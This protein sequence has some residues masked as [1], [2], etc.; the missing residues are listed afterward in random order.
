MV[1]PAKR[2]ELLAQFLDRRRLHIASD[3]SKAATMTELS[4]A[5]DEFIRGLCEG[6]QGIAVI[7]IGGYGRRELGP[8]SDLD[9]LLLHK[10]RL[11]VE[12]FTESLWYTIWDSRVGLDYSVRTVAQAARVAEADPRALF[13]MLDAR[14]I[15]GD[16]F[17][18]AN[19]VS[20]MHDRFVSR[21]DRYR[22][23]MRQNSE[24]RKR[25]SGELAFL[26]EPDVKESHGGLRDVVLLRQLLLADP[27]GENSIARLNE[28]AQLLLK[29]RNLLQVRSDRASNRLNLQDQDGIAQSLGMVD[30][31][32][33]MKQVSEAGRFIS[34]SLEEK[35]R[36]T[37]SR[38]LSHKSIGDAWGAIPKGVFSHGSEICIDPAALGD[39]DAKVI[40]RIAATSLTLGLGICVDALEICSERLEAISDI[41]DQ[42]TLNSLIAILSAGAPG[43][44]VME[45]LDHYGLLDKI[46]PEWG[47][48]RYRPQRNAYHTYTVDRHL[49]E[50]AVGAGKLRRRVKRPDLLIVAALLHDIG[51]GIEGDHSLVGAK[52]ARSISERMGLAEGDVDI[53]ERL[54]VHHLLLADTATRRDISDPKTIEDVAS[55]VVDVTTLDLLEVLTE[56]DSRATGPAAWS[57]WKE[58][59]IAKLCQSTRSYLKDGSI[60]LP[61]SDIGAVESEL[62]SSFDDSLTV[63]HD[64]DYLYIA[65]RDHLGLFSKVAGTLALYN[66]NIVSAD[67]YSRGDVAVEKIK[68]V[69]PFNRDTNW[70]RFEVDLRKAIDDHSYLERRIAE[71]TTSNAR[72]RRSVAES[73]KIPP[74]VTIYDDASDR[75]TVV[76][77]CGPDEVGTLYRLTSAIASMD[78]DIAH[79]KALTIG[80]DVVDTFYIVNRDGST[81]EDSS[82][83]SLLRRSLLAVVTTELTP[84]TRSL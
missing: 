39:Y 60:Q 37:E 17:L 47:H 20:K 16:E 50:A 5:S 18:F 76:E 68:A 58:E 65:A 63:R 81:I 26:L 77:V 21:L 67:V 44:A 28:S 14:L 69:S 31:D 40:L 71:K 51:K 72:K 19:L 62:I 61:G 33:L 84:S 24:S 78:L 38:K 25:D 34:R 70:T 27:S 54:V 48:V 59:L 6:F 9:V 11:A 1:G 2:S 66:L 57:T 83:R 56:A 55:A 49:I 79:A 45:R 80:D 36:V 32:E 12:H 15:Y 10:P 23:I 29:V 43:I 3:W 46:I 22:V 52:L 30:S 64:N 41:W 82:V 73:A 8:H 4:D 74:R 42:Q 35:F 53:I 75:A 13:G 7:A